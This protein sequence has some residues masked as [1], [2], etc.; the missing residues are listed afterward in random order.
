MFCWAEVGV[1]VKHAGFWFN[2]WFTWFE[3]IPEDFDLFLDK[4]QVIVSPSIWAGKCC[5]I[6]SSLL[7]SSFPLGRCIL[8]YV[9]D[10]VLTDIVHKHQLG[11]VTR[12]QSMILKE[13]RFQG[14]SLLSNFFIQWHISLCFQYTRFN[15]PHLHFFVLVQILKCFNQ[16]WEL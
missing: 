8:S 13:C 4:H 2:I 3:L 15:Y 7:W 9:I 12:G 6:A 16:T 10:I 11:L 1:L 14:F 5:A